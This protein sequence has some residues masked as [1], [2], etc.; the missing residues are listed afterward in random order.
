MSL[1]VQ[2]YIYIETALARRKKPGKQNKRNTIEML[3]IT[4]REK[5][6]LPTLIAL[7]P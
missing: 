1:E 3:K 4:S 2:M 5:P 6:H 7:F